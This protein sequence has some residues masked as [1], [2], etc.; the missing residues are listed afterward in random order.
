[1]K[2][3]YD[4]LGDLLLN[5]RLVGMAILAIAIAAW[6]I[7]LSGLIYNCPYCRVQRTALALASIVLIFR[8]DRYLLGRF[9]ATIFVIFG[10]I[11]AIMQ[12]FNSIK[13]MNSGE[14]DWSA[15]WIGSPWILSGLAVIA[16]VWQLFLI[17]GLTDRTR[18]PQA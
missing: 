4:I 11:V 15:L 18:Q 7:D 16:F 8:L 12:H 17:L 2:R 9:V 3:V 5:K 13:K 1:M 10:L 6:A 14:Y